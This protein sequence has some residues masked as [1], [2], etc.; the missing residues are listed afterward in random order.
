MLPYYHVKIRQ[1]CYSNFIK[2]I[3]EGVIALFDREYLIKEYL[4]KQGQRKAWRIPS[5]KNLT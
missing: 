4:I 1:Y 2:T 5:P 3:I